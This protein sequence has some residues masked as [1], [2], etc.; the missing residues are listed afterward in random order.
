[1]PGVEKQGWERMLFEA[2]ASVAAVFTLICQISLLRFVRFVHL[3][4]RSSQMFTLILFITTS[5]LNTLYG[6][7]TQW[8]IHCNRKCRKSPGREEVCCRTRWGHQ[9][10]TIIVVPDILTERFVLSTWALGNTVHL[11]TWA[12]EHF[13]QLRT[14]EHCALKHLSTMSS[15]GEEFLQAY[16]QQHWVGGG[17][18]A[19]AGPQPWDFGRPRN[20]DS[21]GDCFEKWLIVLWAIII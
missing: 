8:S 18:G 15:W 11:G 10:R 20:C 14:C 17:W 7:I 21:G 3:C 5:W 16:G 1:M 4:T 6:N 9:C 13:E 2:S 19:W 12:L